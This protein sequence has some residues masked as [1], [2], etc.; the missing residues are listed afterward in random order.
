MTQRPPILEFDPE[1][2]AIINPH[3]KPGKIALPSHV[4]LCFFQDVLGRLR[5]KGKL[6]VIGRLVSEIGNNPILLLEDAGK[7]IAVVHPGVGAPLAAGFLEEL[8]ALGGKYFI[9]CG[10]CGVLDER[11]AL[12]HPVVVSSAV[13]DEGTSYHYLPPS[14]EVQASP[15]AVRAIEEVLKQNHVDYKV[16]KAWTTD[17]LYRET[18]ARREK[19]VAEGCSVVEMEAAALFAVAKFRGVSLGQVVYGGDLVLPDAWDSRGWARATGSRELLFR[20]AVEACRML[21]A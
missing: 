9:A 17:A 8:I 1:R 2:I 10:G 20:L 15:E 21:E 6:T 14:R 5:R 18:Q 13:R 3:N 4:V 16:G 7:P 19:R 12:G 11:I